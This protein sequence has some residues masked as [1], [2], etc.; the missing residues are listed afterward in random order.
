MRNNE[1]ILIDDE[2]IETEVND[3][4]DDMASDI[5]EFSSF[6]NT[7]IFNLDLNVEMISQYY[8]KDRFDFSPDFQRRSV[9]SVKR[10][11]KFI[12]SIIL[13]LPT[14]SI[15]LAD[16]KI[17]NKYLIVDGKQRLST[18]VE[19]MNEKE[20]FKLKGLEVLKDLEGKTYF[21][22][23]NDS[24][25]SI[26]Y[27]A[28]L[29]YT[30]KT[31]IVRNY[32][33]KLLYFVFARL[34]SGSVPLS[35]QELRHTLYPGEFSNFINNKS[36]ENKYLYKYLNR[37]IS[38]I[39]PRMR[40]AELLCRYYSFKY[41]LDEYDNSV[42]DLLD[43]TYENINKKWNEY[44]TRVSDD[45]RH[46]DES[47]KFIY[48]QLDD[49]AFKLYDKEKDAFSKK[50][51]LMYDLFVPFFSNTD[52]REK[53]YKSENKLDKFVKFAFSNQDFSD[54]FKPTTSSKIKT[55]NRFK[56][57]ESLFKEYFGD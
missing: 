1:Y 48:E 19:F 31:S 50:S 42:S 33:N 37:E 17:L 4:L 16:H 10:K 53:V 3:D 13:N 39:D 46:F 27:N 29:G 18:I 36:K 24:K 14:P 43:Y 26:Y 30:I 21:D 15:L 45:L 9:W 28:F 41:F 47:I 2:E 34:N 20:G 6:E 7:S 49:K 52:N 54:A 56:Y 23:I 44:Y 5:V 55:R 25:L 51:R 12:E 57:L 22:L 8:E 32:N 40:D 11:S 35:S 38:K